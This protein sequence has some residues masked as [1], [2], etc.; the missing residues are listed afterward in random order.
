MSTRFA[1]FPVLALLLVLFA[2]T[3]ERTARAEKEPAS[4]SSYLEIE[5]D[6]PRTGTEAEA[7]DV[8]RRARNAAATRRDGCAAS[9]VVRLDDAG[10]LLRATVWTHLG[11]LEA[12][13][14]AADG[15]DEE[16]AMQAVIDPRRRAKVQFRL[17]RE[18]KHQDG[19]AGYLEV[20]IYRTKP[21]TT[22]EAN[23]ELFD[24][25]REG[26]AGGEGL[27]S[28]AIG[29]SADGRW[30]HLLYWREGAD[31]TKTSKSLMRV[32][33]VLRWIRSLDFKRFRVYK[34]DT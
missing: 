12:A 6:V 23:L 30:V 25:A 3:V 1:L 2:T 14:L 7:V 13:S 15:S 4:R 5:I 18:Y 34:G 33:A 26:F 29:L 19:E 21:G 27:L 11:A 31:Y 32:P 20:V 17:L 16:K 22:R 10:A 28:H 24:A 8:A 9:H